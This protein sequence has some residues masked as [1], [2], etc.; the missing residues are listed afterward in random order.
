M[1]FDIKNNRKKKGFLFFKKRKKRDK[2]NCP[3]LE[4]IKG[5]LS[6]NQIFYR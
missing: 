4:S 1:D 3:S 2:K 5:H 6:H